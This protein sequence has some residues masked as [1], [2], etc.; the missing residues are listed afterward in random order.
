VFD[1]DKK[2]ILYGF[3]NLGKKIYSKSML[4]IDYV[5]DNNKSVR[6]E[7]S[8]LVRSPLE[9]YSLLNKED[10]NLIICI[11]GAEMSLSYD[12]IYKK[13]SD[14]NVC[15]FTEILNYCNI[16]DYVFLNSV[17][18]YQKNAENIGMVLS[19]LSDKT[20]C[21]NYTN[22]YMARIHNNLNLLSP[23]YKDNHYFPK[24]LYNMLDDEVYVDCGAY[25]GDTIKLFKNASNNIYKKIIAIEPDHK[26]I[27]NLMRENVNIHVGNA[28]NK[29]DVCSNETTI[30]SLVPDATLIK[31]DIEGSELNALYGTIECIKN[32]PVFAI[33]LYHKPSDFWS[34]PQFLINNTE[35]YK[36]HV[37]NHGPYGW[38]TVFYAI[39]DERSNLR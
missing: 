30:Q 32:R 31:M 23:S 35:N 6:S 4:S 29:R 3:G 9:L 38:D 20:S 36:Y 34:I 12:T 33:A 16:D 27:Y 11:W 7:Y 1:V 21:I 14:F 10:Y 15:M 26:H 5:V 19:K 39:P 13:Y 25:N 17:N 24:W 18:K 8:P 28:G 37:V 22:E 2:N